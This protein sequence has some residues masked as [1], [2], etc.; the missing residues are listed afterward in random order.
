MYRV[1]VITRVI[2]EGADRLLQ[3]KQVH[4]Y[5]RMS[6]SY[7]RVESLKGLTRDMQATSSPLK[8]WETASRY[9]EHREV[10]NT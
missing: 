10:H 4:H 2:T 9:H 5:F 7:K 8:E 6:D 3:H 1:G